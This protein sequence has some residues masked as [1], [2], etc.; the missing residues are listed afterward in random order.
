MK[1]VCVKRGGWTLT[2]GRGRPVTH[3]KYGEICTISRLNMDSDQLHIALFEY[4]PKS[5]YDAAKFKPVQSRA[6]DISIFTQL[7]NPSKTR[8]SA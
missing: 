7:L 1:V 8:A 4:H 2:S 5:L 6:T 3:P